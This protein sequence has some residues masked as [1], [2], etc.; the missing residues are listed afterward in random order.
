MKTYIWALGYAGNAGV[1][2]IVAEKKLQLLPFFKE[3]VL[4][5]IVSRKEL[6][7][8]DWKESVGLEEEK[9]IPVH[10]GGILGALYKLSQ[11][12]GKGMRIRIKD[13]PILQA[14]I[15]IC[16]FF[17]INPY[18]LYSHMY[19]LLCED[20]YLAK[21]W[22]EKGLQAVCIGELVRGKENLIVDKWG[23]DY[24]QKVKADEIY[25]V[26]DTCI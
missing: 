19:I 13:I 12:M 6:A 1:K 25:K 23:R 9:I 16:E 5:D 20:L 26:L 17:A 21:A 15:E 8:E 22:E 2:R 24:I 14:D 10:E 18:K 11:D 4:E 3:S 7:I